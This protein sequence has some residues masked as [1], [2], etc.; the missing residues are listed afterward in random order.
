MTCPNCLQYVTPKARFC[1]TCGSQIDAVERS[2]DPDRTQYII[3]I[4]VGA[5]F[6]PGLLV[7]FLR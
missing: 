2:A 1:P 7:E 4:V 5:V 6:G 3:W